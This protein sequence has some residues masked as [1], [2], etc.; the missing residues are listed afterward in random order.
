MVERKNKGKKV[1]DEQAQVSCHLK[2]S[3]KT[4]FLV[5]KVP[6]KR[7]VIFCQPPFSGLF[8]REKKLFLAR[9]VCRPGQK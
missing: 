5:P 8:L 6:K 1:D 4:V 9:C 2:N 3:T 7:G